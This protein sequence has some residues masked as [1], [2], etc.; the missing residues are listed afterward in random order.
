MR[1]NML[2]PVLPTTLRNVGIHLKEC[3]MCL[4]QLI[5][6]PVPCNSISYG[7]TTVISYKNC[8][9]FPQTKRDV[10][11]S[12]LSKAGLLEMSYPYDSPCHL[13]TDTYAAIRQNTLRALAVQHLHK[14]RVLIK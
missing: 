2:P 8:F 7:V 14:G 6:V 9:N 10:K 12:G 1:R 11:H 13:I 4:S 5:S 3:T